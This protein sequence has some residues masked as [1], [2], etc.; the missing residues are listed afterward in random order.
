MSRTKKQN[1]IMRLVL[2]A[3]LALSVFIF[4]G[5]K[6]HAAANVIESGDNFTL[7]DDGTLTV[8]A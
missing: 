8:M 1:L 2:G 3:F 4:T 7:T 5:E 6:A